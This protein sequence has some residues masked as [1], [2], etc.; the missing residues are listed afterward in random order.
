MGERAD[1]S[2]VERGKEPE[3]VIALF[4]TKAVF[5]QPKSKLEIAADSGNLIK[6]TMQMP[7]TNLLSSSSFPCPSPSIIVIIHIRLTRL[8]CIRRRLGLHLLPPCGSTSDADLDLRRRQLIMRLVHR[9]TRSA[10]LPTPLT[11]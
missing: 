3:E 11:S 2:K 9:C 5:F 10:R 8:A 1:E 6:C 7:E 4:K